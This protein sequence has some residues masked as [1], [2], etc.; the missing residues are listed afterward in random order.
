M[1]SRGLIR[2]VK[3][4]SYLDNN[5]MSKKAVKANDLFAQMTV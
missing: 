1:G 3:L 5:G 4:E 2:E